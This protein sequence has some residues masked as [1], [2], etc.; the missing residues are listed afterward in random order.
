MSRR[1]LR[2]IRALESFAG[3]VV[4][5]SANTIFAEPFDTKAS[6]A[7]SKQELGVGLGIAA[8]G[9]FTPGG[10]YIAGNYLYIVC[11]KLTGSKSRQLLPTVAVVKDAMGRKGFSVIM[12]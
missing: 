8:G 1:S 4:I 3:L 10:A 7:V 2:R 11:R 6:I 9:D 5:L 12:A